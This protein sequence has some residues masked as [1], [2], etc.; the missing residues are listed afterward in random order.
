MGRK[1]G[2]GVRQPGEQGT[3]REIGG[4]GARLEKSDGEEG[5]GV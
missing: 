4:I 1:E 5:N 2:K 3:S